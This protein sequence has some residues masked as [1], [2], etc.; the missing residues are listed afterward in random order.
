MGMTNKTESPA[1]IIIAMTG[2]SGSAY[3]L[4]LLEILLKAGHPVYLLVS[5][6]AQMVLAM[7]TP[8]DIPSRPAD[9]C[10][11]L[12]EYFQTDTSLLTV[13]SREDWTAPIASGSHRAQHM[14]VCPCTTGTLAAIANGNSDNLMERA[15]DVMLKEQRK[16]ILVVRETPFSIIHLENMLKL[17]HAGATILPANPGFYHNP[18]TMDDLVDFVV[19]RILDHLHIEHSLLPRWGES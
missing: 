19:A 7:E 12:S 16:L 2:A 9:M 8:L 4:R 15:A 13:F 11:F 14:V 17:A 5:K 18:Q 3:G 10:Q 1:P 6:A